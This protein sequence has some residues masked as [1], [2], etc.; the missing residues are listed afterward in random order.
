MIINVG[1]ISINDEY[2]G[3]TPLTTTYL[4]DEEGN[5]VLDY[6]RLPIVVIE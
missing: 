5:L 2:T 1:K 3:E 6:M 4:V